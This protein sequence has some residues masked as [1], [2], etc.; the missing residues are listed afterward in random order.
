MDFCLVPT[1]CLWFFEIKKSGSRLYVEKNRKEKSGQRKG[2]GYIKKTFISAIF[3]L[4]FCVLA[5]GAGSDYNSGGKIT[6]IRYR[7]R[8]QSDNLIYRILFFLFNAENRKFL[9]REKEGFDEGGAYREISLFNKC[10]LVARFFSQNGIFA[11]KI[12]FSGKEWAEELNDEQVK[13]WFGMQKFSRSA[14]IGDI[15]LADYRTAK[16]DYKISIQAQKKIV[17]PVADEFVSTL[18]FE[19]KALRKSG[20]SADIDIKFWVAREGKFKGQL[21]KCVFKKSSWPFI[22][23][24]IIR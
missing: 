22:A 6:E 4:L 12:D 20:Q 24:E 16:N 17:F 13:I 19:G 18:Y 8:V 2:V 21:V 15:F 9:L 5:V 3:L 14:E 11:A 7:S 23:I 10:R 1:P